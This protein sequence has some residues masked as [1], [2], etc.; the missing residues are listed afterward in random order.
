M[1]LKSFPKTRIIL[2]LSTCFAIVCPSFADDGIPPIVEGQTPGMGSTSSTTSAPP[3]TDESSATTGSTTAGA[4]KEPESSTKSAVPSEP[5]KA[6]EERKPAEE[7]RPETNVSRPAPAAATAPPTKLFGRIEELSAGAGARFPLKMQAMVPIRDPSLDARDIKL[8]A[9]TNIQQAFPIDFRGQW[10]GELTIWDSRTDPSYFQFDRAEA[11]KESQLLRRGTK[12]NIVANFYQAAKGIELQPCEVVFQGTDNLSD[13]MKMMGGS[14][15]AGQMGAL[16]AL[17]GGGNS[18]AFANMKIPIIFSL[19]FGAPL[20]SGSRGVS[21]NTLKSTLMKNQLRELAKG[22]MEQQ[23]VT[24]D[25]DTNNSTG[26]TQTG[27]SESVLRFTHMNNNQVYLQCAYVYYRNDGKFQAKYI[28]YGTLNR[29]NG[30]QQSGMTPYAGGASNPFGGMMPG[31]GGGANPFGGMMPAG[32]GGGA[33][34]I[35]QEMQQMQ[36]MIQQMN[37]GR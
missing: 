3:K 20:E 4:T 22:V 2:A 31:A 29:T 23:V 32:S 13:Q 27:Y 24:R 19:H 11:E 8:S 36:K 6:M 9:K 26:K 5:K 25:S 18:S 35:Q 7:R 1:G 34:A 28:L 37:G 16:G 21:G 33:G 10:S 12:G 17:L 15:G 30:A 14:G